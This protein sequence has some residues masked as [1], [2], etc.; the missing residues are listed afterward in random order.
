MSV[1]SQHTKPLN[2]LSHYWMPFTA[3]RQFKQ[4]P[5]LLAQAEG[6]FYSDIHGRSVLDGTAGLW[7]CNAG[8]SRRQITEAVS[9]Q[10]STLDYAPSFQMGHP[11]A[12]ELAERLA[13]MAPAGID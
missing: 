5:R 9:R 10:L 6:M 12:F 11:L 8:H 2:N 13:S 4:Q 3:N 7:C 1:E